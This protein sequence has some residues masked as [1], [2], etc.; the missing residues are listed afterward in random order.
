MFHCFVRVYG[1]VRF[2]PCAHSAS[3]PIPV[4]IDGV[5]RA[6]KQVLFASMSPRIPEHSLDAPDGQPVIV[7]Y[8]SGGPPSA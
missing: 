6:I 1:V 7:V 3:R 5:F 8:S 2:H 4:E